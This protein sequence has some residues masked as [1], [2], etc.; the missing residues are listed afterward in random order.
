MAKRLSEAE[1]AKV[2]H[3]R[4][5]KHLSFGELS[6]KYGVGKTT[7]HRKAQAD[8]WKDIDSS[9]PPEPVK[10]TPK[11]KPV[12]KIKPDCLQDEP[13]QPKAK[14]D[15]VIKPV[16]P[17]P[18]EQVDEDEEE[19]T[20]SREERWQQIRDKRNEEKKSG[21]TNGTDDNQNSFNI[22]GYIDGLKS[23][24]DPSRARDRKYMSFQLEQIGTHLTDLSSV[25]EAENLGK[26]RPQFCRIAHQIALLGGTPSILAETLAVSEQTIHNWLKTYPEFQIAWIG[27]KDFADAQVTQALF[28]RAVGFSQ[29]VEDFK[30]ERGE[31]V[32]I[33]KTI[34]FPPDI[35]AAQYWL[36]NRRPQDWKANVEFKE[37]IPAAIIDQAAAD[38]MYEN[39]VGKAHD[40]KMQFQGRAERMGLTLDGECEEI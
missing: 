13:V 18:V 26:Y 9:V 3:D 11:P 23:S 6:E 17:E 14:K 10:K 21:T 29:V 40:L 4:E 31:L 8:G 33:E 38:E 39:I 27:G 35:Q 16:D 25:Y 2:R 1:W 20:L 7:I 12:G 15:K 24:F 30:T 28:K 37:P 32:P 22:Q 5:K 19:N 36:N 34:V